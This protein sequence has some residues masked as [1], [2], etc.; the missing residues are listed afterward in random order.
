MKTLHKLLA[1][2]LVAVAA[3]ANA[4]SI[5]VTVDGVNV[6][7][8]DVEPTMVRGRVLVPL[9]GVF[10]QM[11][12][13][14]SWDEQSQTVVVRRGQDDIKLPIGSTTAWVNGDP[15]T[16]DTPAMT[17]G[18]R[19]MVPLRFLGEAL[20]AD[21]NWLSA[22]RIVQINTVSTNTPIPPTP[23]QPVKRYHWMTIQSGTV[24][25][26]RL[27]QRLSSN[28][29]TEGD[30]FTAS[31]DVNDGTEY[32]GLPKGSIIEG[33][34][35]IAK[36]KD[37]G[38]PGVLGLAFD[39]IRMPDGTTYSVSGSLI[40]LDSNSV[41]NRDGRLVA[42]MN[43]RNDNLKFVGYG[44]GAGAILSILTKGNMLTDA[45]IG[46]ALGFLYGEIQRDPSKSKNVVLQSGSTFGV[47]LKQDLS[48]RVLDNR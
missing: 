26:M 31:L 34:V 24:L 39:R 28:G 1:C 29:S 5:S 21:V 30:E 23:P 4:Q 36:P 20:K 18:G 17:L 46:G 43:K 42:K 22:S 25:P 12:A 19:A 7:F 3:G 14:V 27:D 44:A 16:L 2:A 32:Q 33:H 47:R 13:Y 37:G 11:G 6:Y 9:R 35:S 10:E 15:I 45:L 38:T 40:G 8:R 48:V 41:E